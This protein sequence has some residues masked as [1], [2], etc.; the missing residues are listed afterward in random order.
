VKGCLR[1]QRPSDRRWL[2][3]AIRRTGSTPKHPTSSLG[4]R[5]DLPRLYS[6][7]DA[8]IRLTSTFA[9]GSRPP[10]D[11]VRLAAAATELLRRQATGVPRHEPL[12]LPGTG[13]D[14]PRQR[15]AL[16]TGARRAAAGRRTCGDPARLG[17]LHGDRGQSRR[18]TAV[19]PGEADGGVERLRVRPSTIEHRAG[20]ARRRPRAAPR[21]A[22]PLLERAAPRLGRYTSPRACAVA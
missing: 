8:R 16:S 11:A 18:E 7:A 22:L 15:R 12:D 4:A 3:Q 9:A 14:G 13:R 10:A 5:C 17:S 2:D 19:G 20:R 1:R 6:E 21:H